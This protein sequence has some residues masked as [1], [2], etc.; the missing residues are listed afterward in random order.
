LTP[1]AHGD[2]LAR[3]LERT[4]ARGCLLDV[5]LALSVQ[6]AAAQND[7]VSPVT[8]ITQN[9]EPDKSH[10]QSVRTGKERLGPKASDEQRVDNCNV[11]LALRGSRPRPDDCS[12]GVNTRSKR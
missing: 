1:K 7:V 4:N 6:A 12:N 8:V 5:A 2:K 3:L 11:P 10:P 9:A